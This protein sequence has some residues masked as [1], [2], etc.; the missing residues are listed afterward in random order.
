MIKI[1]AAFV[2]IIAATEAFAANKPSSAVAQSIDSFTNS[3]MERW[4]VPGLAVAVLHDGEVIYRLVS[5]LRDVEY[6]LPVTT[7]TL[8]AVGSISKSFTVAGLA[9]LARAGKLDWDA[10]VRLICRNSS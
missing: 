9:R 3:A 2:L 6:K 8:F 7:R 4:E 1:L 5:G 10:P